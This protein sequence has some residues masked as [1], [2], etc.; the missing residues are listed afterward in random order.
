M[1]D[2]QEASLI[3]L[4]GAAGDSPFLTECATHLPSHACIQNS[5]VLLVLPCL[6]MKVVTPY[7][8]HICKV[9]Q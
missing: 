1:A 8:N 2:I 6:I 7:Y 3:T 9:N 5:K 4:C